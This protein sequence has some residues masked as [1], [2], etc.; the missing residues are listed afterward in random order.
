M[1]SFCCV[2]IVRIYKKLS[3][4]VRAPLHGTLISGYHR[5]VRKIWH[6]FFNMLMY[7]IFILSVVNK[8]K[9]NPVKSFTAYVFHI[10]PPFWSWS[11][12]LRL[13][14]EFCTFCMLEMDTPISESIN[15]HVYVS[16]KPPPLSKKT[17]LLY[18]HRESFFRSRFLAGLSKLQNKN[19]TWITTWS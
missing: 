2:L 15:I 6:L 19:F 4:W 3:E 5:V 11:S 10:F 12:E 8:I 14:N 17:W 1:Q 7:D 16:Q 13:F 18:M 9:I